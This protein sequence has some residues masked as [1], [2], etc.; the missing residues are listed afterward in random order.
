MLV[1]LHIS[2]TAT[3]HC[4]LSVCYTQN[5]KNPKKIKISTTQKKKYPYILNVKRVMVCNNKK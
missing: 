4:C 1:K 3:T 2:H 5:Q